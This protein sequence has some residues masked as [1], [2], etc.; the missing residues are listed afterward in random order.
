MN[1]MIE[2][3]NGLGGYVS[4][5]LGD[6]WTYTPFLWDQLIEKYKPKCI[7]DIGCGEGHATKY[8]IDK[9]IEAYGIEGSSKAQETKVID[10]KHFILHDFKEPYNHRVKADMIWCCEFVEHIEEKYLSNV[11]DI[12]NKPKVRVIAMTHAYPGQGGWH[13]VN[14]RMP[15]YW[16]EKIEELGFKYDEYSVKSRRYAPNSHWERSGLIFIRS[17]NE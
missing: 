4:G 2:D 14:C 12:M 9:G 7:Y 16:I 1:K 13:H 11:L 15:I 17:E 3:I 8:F 5:S 10:D 6:P